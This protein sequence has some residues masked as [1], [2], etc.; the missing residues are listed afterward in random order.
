MG[1]ITPGTIIA[2]DS[3]P[4]GLVSAGTP[5]PA[6]T[7]ASAQPV[8]DTPVPAAAAGPVSKAVLCTNM[9]TAE[10]LLDDEDYEDIVLDIEEECGKAGALLQ[11]IIPR[12]TEGNT[13]G[14][15]KVFL[16]YSEVAGAQ[17]AIAMLHGRKFG[18]QTVIATYFDE[19]ALD[20]GFYDEA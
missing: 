8:G 7:D 14:V 3:S 10:E 20:L 4:V 13:K 16:K 12:P 2:M 15:G 5:A 17:A 11:V 19:Q 9:V 1:L 6:L 18:G